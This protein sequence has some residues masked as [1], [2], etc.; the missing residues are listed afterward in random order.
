MLFSSVI[1]IAG[2]LPCV[3]FIYY[4]ILNKSRQAQ[5]ILL[6]LASLFFYAWGEPRFV[7]IMLASATGNWIFGILT[8]KY[9]SNKRISKIL[10]TIMLIFNLSIIFVFKYLIFT[11]SNINLIFDTSFSIKS[12]ELPLGISFFT[13]HAISYVMDIRRGKVEAQRNFLNV[14]LY[15]SFFPQ[16]IA[17][18]IVRYHTIS[19]QILN[20]KETFEEFS[21][22]VCRFIIGFGKKILLAN[23]F[24]GI[25][26]LSFTLSQHNECSIAFAWM[27]AVSYTFQIYFD[28]SGYSDMAIGL[29]RMFG[30]KFL[31]NFNHPYVSKSVSEFWRR[32]HISLGSFFRDYVYFPLGGSRVETKE[33]LIL[34]L[35]VVWFLT[36][37]WHGANWTFIVWGLFYFVFITFE[38]LTGFE[39][40]GFNSLKH[41][42]TMILVIIGWVI[43]KSPSIGAAVSYLKIML[44]MSGSN[45]IDSNASVYLKEN[46]CF[47]IAGFVFSLPVTQNLT[48]YLAK[49]NLEDNYL[50]EIA[51]AIA[52]AFVFLLAIAYLV[53]GSYN[54]FIYF[55][56]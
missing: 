33:R 13:F 4:I 51:R 5:N 56:F 48:R 1:F 35:F 46:I 18:P 9:R 26:N 42:Y 43:F 17:G 49:K 40:K 25:A 11:L 8:E 41:I 3:L 53:K 2:F 29:G 28:F 7:P 55:N 38:K 30:F 44:F 19:D 10:I 24:A 21:S 52:L 14:V 39:Q 54:P 37:L 31:E 15:I 27:G 22:G 47:F 12:V 50:V 36:G 20:R 32:W 34:N 45:L 16:L 23:N 6:V